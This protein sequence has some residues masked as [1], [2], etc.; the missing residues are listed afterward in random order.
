MTADNTK[1][2]AIPSVSRPLV[3]NWAG[4]HAC[5]PVMLYRPTTEEQIQTLV[6]N[7]RGANRRIRAVGARHSPGDLFF[8]DEGEYL[9]SMDGLNQTFNVRNSFPIIPSYRLFILMR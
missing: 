9:V 6:A 3:K 4:T 7:A 2:D 1:Y 8:C 5:Q